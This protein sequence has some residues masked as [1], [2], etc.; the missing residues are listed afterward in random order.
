MQASTP[1]ERIEHAGGRVV[2]SVDA[3]TREGWLGLQPILEYQLIS[4][5]SFQLT[6]G[7]LVAAVLAVLGALLVSMLL[8]RTLVRYGKQRQNVN[9]AALY[10]VA[11][12]AHYLLLLIGVMLA[13][14]LAGVPVGEFAVFAGALGIGLGFGLREIFANFIGGLVLL[15]DQSLKVG[16][17]IELD[18]DVRGTV[19]DINMRATR[20]ITNDNIDIMVPNAEFMTGRVVNWTHR[21]ALRRMRVPFKVA[22]GVDKELVKKAALE[23]AAKVPFTLATEG[24]HRPQVWLADFG[25]GAVEYLLAVWLTE[26]ATKRNAAIKAA[27]LWEL[28]TSFKKHGIEIPLP[29]RDLNL[30]SVFGLTGEDAIALL[31]GQ[32]ISSPDTQ[33]P[34]ASELS[35]AERE[36]LGNNDARDYAAPSPES[37]QH[38]AAPDPS[39]GQ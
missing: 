15:F 16:D 35:A 13:L 14:Q 10:T 36:T 18:A 33:A 34:A 4:L 3:A 1:A 23:A 37:H 30:R 7:G 38:P 21:D 11:R 26:E 5:S 8:R 28:D 17:F 9:H 29:Q 25:D 31:R 39:R 27:Y 19:R 22:Y 6:V 32:P 12:V 24:R 2:D 20:I